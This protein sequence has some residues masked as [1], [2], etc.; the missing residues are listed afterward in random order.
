VAASTVLL[1]LGLNAQTAAPSSTSAEEEETEKLEKI[2]VVGSRIKRLDAETPQP[3]LRIDRE[4]LQNTGFSNLGDALRALPFSNAVSIT[5]EDSNVGFASGTSSINLRGLGNNQTLILINGRRAVPSGAG[6]FN[7]F[8]S[9]IDLNQMPTS[10]VDSIEVL[11]DGASAIYGSD[12]VAG[13]I[14]INLRKDYVGAALDVSYGNLFTTDS[15]ETSVFAIFGAAAG[16]TSITITASYFKKNPVANRDID[17]SSTADMRADKT[18]TGVGEIDPTGSFYTGYDWR[19]SSSFPARFFLPNSNTTRSF[20]T[21]TS[22]PNPDSAVPLSRATGAG[23]YDFQTVSW[24]YPEIESR[25]MTINARHEVSDTLYGFLDASFQTVN[26]LNAAAGSPF[27]TTDKGAG[28]NNRLLVPAANPF[29]PYG[30]RYRPGE[31][32]DILLSTYRLVNAGERYTDATSDYPRVIFGVGGNLGYSWTWETSYMWARG[33]YEN[34]NPGTSFDSLVQQALQGV[35]IDGDLLYANPFG[36]E[37]PRITDYYSG[38]NPISSTFEA[39]IWDISASGDLVDMPAGPLGLAVGAEVR[40]EN[41]NDVRTIENETGNIVGGSEGFGYSG[42]RRVQSLFAELSIPIVA[43]L[44]AQ[45]A[46]RYEDYSDFG[47]TTK[48]KVAVAYRPAS[49]VMLRGSFSQSFKAPDLAYLYSTG[50]VSFTGSQIFDP[51]RPDQPATQIKT[52][53]RGTAGAGFTLQPEET[54]TAYLGAVFDFDS[55]PFRN[56]SFEAGVFRFDQKNRITRDGAEFTLRNEDSLPA[57]RVVRKPVTAEEAAEGI[58]VG[59]LDYVATD[60]YNADKVIYEGL[61]LAGS[62][63]YDNDRLGRFRFGLA[64]TLITDFNQ[65]VTDSLGVSSEIDLDGTNGYPNWRVTGTLA[66]NK[67]DWAASLYYQ[68]V[69]GMP[70]EPFPSLEPQRRLNVQASYAGFF[71]SRITVGVRNVFDS[72]PPY[73]LYSSGSGYFSGVYNPEPAFWYVRLAREF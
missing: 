37:D 56:F 47:D 25:G 61:D 42:S 51:K 23:F 27:T 12:A 44:E 45:L 58:T 59:I 32:Q 40:Q 35:V 8:Q 34:R 55:G 1:T 33:T 6:A 72:A 60:W 20:L 38:E 69:G 53:G 16:K 65:T 48:P 36:P 14:N 31:G 2:S 50:S 28:L 52:L 73:D 54:D 10:A 26:I 63:R 46:A 68:Y 18:G 49:W 71:D 21:P 66:W 19:S 7:G 11:K 17:F 41:N 62:Y 24:M 39:K 43:G 57:G 30:E 5:P 15:G 70:N 22:D 64:G 3:V 29:N 67:G 9:V 13:V 4:S